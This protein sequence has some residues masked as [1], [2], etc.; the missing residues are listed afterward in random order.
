M[1]GGNICCGL[2]A[3]VAPD[4]LSMLPDERNRS[5]RGHI[6]GGGG[7]FCPALPDGLDFLRLAKEVRLALDNLVEEEGCGIDQQLG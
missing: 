3:G 5:L 2:I 1:T 7:T 4:I 6:A